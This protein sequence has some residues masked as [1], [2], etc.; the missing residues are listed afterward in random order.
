VEH[1]QTKLARIFG[2]EG[3]AWMRRANPLSVWTR[4]TVLPLLAIAI[5]SRTWIG[6]WSLVPLPLRPALQRRR[7][8]LSRGYER[9]KARGRVSRTT[10][11]ARRLERSRRS[12]RR[13][14]GLTR[15][16]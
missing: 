1:P 12:S 11:V 15:I 13:L 9:T 7:T 5:W 16:V 8:I 3:D 10:S 2:L 6:W 4:F 14:R